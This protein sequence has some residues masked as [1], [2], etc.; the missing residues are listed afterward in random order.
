MCDCDEESG[1]GEWD[2]TTVE[3]PAGAESGLPQLPQEAVITALRLRSRVNREVTFSILVGKI[4]NTELSLL[5]ETTLTLS[6]DDIDSIYKKHALVPF[7][8][9]DLKVMDRSDSITDPSFGLKL[10]IESDAITTVTLS[11]SVDLTGISAAFSGCF[12]VRR[13]C[14]HSKCCKG[15]K[16][17]K[18]CWA[19][20]YRCEARPCSC[21]KGGECGPWKK[22]S[23]TCLSC[24]SG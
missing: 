14:V 20:N 10:T 7:V 1:L 4:S 15:K 6:L 23:D 2:G 18:V 12:T 16:F 11:T 3:L 22:E 19:C 17:Y 13:R 8:I 5:S 24:F 9:S 21:S